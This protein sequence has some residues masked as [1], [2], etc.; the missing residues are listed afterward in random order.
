MTESSVEAVYVALYQMFS[1]YVSNIILATS[2]IMYW[3]SHQER[4]TDEECSSFF[5][6]TDFSQSLQGIQVSYMGL[7]LEGS[8]RASLFL[9]TAEALAS[10]QTVGI[11]CSSENLNL[12]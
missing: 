10:F 12:S 3:L 1:L 8:I 11:H 9:Y 4:L 5:S 7:L 2:I 6:L